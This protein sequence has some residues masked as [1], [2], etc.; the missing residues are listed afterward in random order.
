MSI[1]YGHFNN[2]WFITGYPVFDN[3]IGADAPKTDYSLA[4][5]HTE[6]FLLSGMIMI[7][8]DNAGLCGRIENLATFFFLHHFKKAAPL[9]GSQCQGLLVIGRF[10][11]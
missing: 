6:L 2:D 5:Y 1:K 8:A 3:L 10:G 4:F 9:I 7:A 11:I